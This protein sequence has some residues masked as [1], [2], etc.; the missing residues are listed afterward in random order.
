MLRAQCPEGAHGW[1]IAALDV[2]AEELATLGKAEGVDGGSA[3]EDGVGGDIGADGGELSGEV[4]EEG[5]TKDISAW[6][7]KWV[8]DGC[9]A[10]LTPFGRLNCRWIV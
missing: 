3:G 4:A 9:G 8:A 2:A 5:A 7:V 10:G 6:V 1:C